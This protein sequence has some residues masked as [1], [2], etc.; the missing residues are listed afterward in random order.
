MQGLGGLGGL[1]EDLDLYSEGGESPGCSRAPSGGCLP[2]VWV[3]RSCEI[4]ARCVH[5]LGSTL[6][7]QRLKK[8]MKSYVA[9]G[10]R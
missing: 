9:R 10:P 7:M 1:G 8:I 3:L 5:A 2:D 4:S 6:G